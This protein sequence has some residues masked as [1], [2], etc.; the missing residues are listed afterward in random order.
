VTCF[1]PAELRTIRAVVLVIAG[2]C[3]SVASAAAQETVAITV[4]STV[5]FAVTDVSQ[6]TSGTPNPST[7]S[8]SNASLILGRVVR[9]SVQA[10]AAAFTPPGG[11]S[12]PAANVS[13]NNLGASG[14]TGWNGTL[15][16]TSYTLVFQSDPARTSGHVDL[17][18]T[19]AAP[20]SGLRAGNHQ[21]M[22]RWKVESIAP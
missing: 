12:I 9:V 16:S 13:W 1:R 7:I 15:G 18:W 20:V 4:P 5:S 21:L 2:V 8:F 19:L 11:P 6:R 17:G 10:D 22:I 14:G 3:V